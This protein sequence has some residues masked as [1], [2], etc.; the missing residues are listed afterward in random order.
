MALV[1]THMMKYHAAWLAKLFAKGFSST[2]RSALRGGLALPRNKPGLSADREIKTLSL[3]N[4]ICIPLLNYQQEV[5]E[6]VVS[7]GQM[8]R[9]GD[10]LAPGIVASCHGVIESIEPHAVNHPSGMHSLCV[11]ISPNTEKSNSVALH[12][13]QEVVTAERIS[14]CA[15]HGLGGAGFKTTE[16][17]NAIS[18][19]DHGFVDTLIINAVECEPLISCD[20]SLIASHAPII[21]TAIEGLIDLT[22][23]RRCLLAIED[24]K[25]AAIEQLEIAIQD[26]VQA[27]R[28]EVIYLAPI[29]PSGAERPL[30]ERLT[31]KQTPGNIFPASLGILCINVATALATEHARQGHALVSRIVTIAGD[32]AE[33]PMNVRVTFGTSVYDVIQQTG[34]LTHIDNARIRVGGPLSGFLI[35]DLSAPITATT[36][37]ITLERLTKSEDIHPCIRCGACSD[38]CP[39]DLLPQQLNTYCVNENT[40]KAKVFRLSECIE[41][42]CCDVVCPSNIPLTQTFRFAKGLIREQDRQSLLATQAE[43][44]YQQRES[45]LADRVEKRALKR[46]AARA[47]LATSKDPIAD[48]LARAKQ[49]RKR[50]ADD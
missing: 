13:T 47:R 49:R 30:V 36:N 43:S 6:P 20:E 8:V 28:F 12:P 38:V 45:R 44:R 24:D 22:Q 18:A 15:I 32:L 26:Y 42:A 40:E 31:G 37:C 29:Y 21:V 7:I 33:N 35:Q 41:C 14:A 2:P 23:C 19:T 3:A 10:T 9:P 5:L 48:A 50:S 46:E 16:K 11:V 1:K 4:T 25:T 27:V 39:V 34:N 17:L